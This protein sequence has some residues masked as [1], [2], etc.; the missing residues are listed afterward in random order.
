MPRRKRR[1]VAQEC[2]NCF[3]CGHICTACDNPINGCFCDDL[4]NLDTECITQCEDCGA[5]GVLQPDPPKFTQKGV[6]HA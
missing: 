1:E 6:G 4:D 3:G 5:T 2:P